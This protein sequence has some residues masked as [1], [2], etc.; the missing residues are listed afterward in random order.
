MQL[1]EI[2]LGKLIEPCTINNSD[3]FYGLNS[4]KGISIQKCFIETKANME[5]VSLKPYLL[6]EPESFA[7]V[8]TTSRNGEK[9]TIAF[10]DTLDTFIVS[11]SYQVFKVK[12][13]CRLLPEYLFIWFRR[14]EFDRYSR[15]NSWGSAREVFSFDDM[16]SIQFL[17]PSI[18]IQQKAVDAYNAI[19]TN[20]AAYTNGLDD[21]KLTGDLYM[22]NIKKKYPRM[23]IG[24]LLEEIDIRNKGVKIS[25]VLG[26]N[27]EKTFMPSVAN[28]EETDI[29]KYKVI[30]KGQFA[31]SPMQTGRD[32]TIRLALYSNSQKAVISPAYSVL[33]S[34]NVDVLE[35]YLMIWFKREESDRYG[36]F[37][38]DGSVR[39]SLDVPRFFEIE[40]PIP[41][42]EIQQSIV[43]IYNAQ[44]ER[45]EIANKLN[46]ISR[47]ICPV[48]I[49]N[50]LAQ[51]Q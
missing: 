25:I 13:K 51:A 39:A 1:T 30:E 5:D 45:Q 33:Q 49:S 2:L 23:P 36:W 3:E 50:S 11:S 28:L 20:L 18:E 47:E 12:D 7:Y 21:L 14:A 22:D 9:I 37:L 40:I 29:S 24:S 42:L 26:I 41:P 6:V 16:C 38:S 32:E 27:I 17:L 4:V 19:N 31:Y 48:L 34:K 44:F 35:E 46:K 15:F 10:N 8:P 43:D